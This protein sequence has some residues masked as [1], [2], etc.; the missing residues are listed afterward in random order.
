[1][2]WKWDWPLTHKMFCLP[3]VIGDSEL[4]Y[5][6]PE[7]SQAGRRERYAVVLL[8]NGWRFSYYNSMIPWTLSK[9]CE[10][11]FSSTLYV[12]FSFHFYHEWD[13]GINF[14][15]NWHG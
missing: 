11:S 1:M 13:L 12:K 15:L 4:L 14:Q 9:V 8:E 3:V 6:L 7:I 2:S 10:N 5:T